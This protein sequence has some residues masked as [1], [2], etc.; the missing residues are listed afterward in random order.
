M[1]TYGKV[2][3]D[4]INTKLSSLNTEQ[5]NVLYE[6]A[7]LIKNGTDVK[8][9]WL[10]HKNQFPELNDA[11]RDELAKQVFENS[12]VIY[13]PP[14]NSAIK[15]WMQTEFLTNWMFYLS[16]FIAICAV[17]A[18]FKNYWKLLI[19]FLI[20]YLAP[21]FR[22]LF[23]PILLTYELWIISV[24]CIFYGCSVEEFVFRTVIIHV[25]LCLLWS[26]STAIFAKEY[27]MKRYV[28]KIENDFWGQ[29]PWTA[30]K[31]IS[32]PAVILTIALS[33]VLYRV[34]DDIFYN[35][36]IVISG[37]TAIYALP[38]WRF[39][40]KYL[41]PVLF[42]FKSD[43]RDRSINSLGGCIVIAILVTSV[44]ILQWNP[45][46]Y[47]VIAALLSLLTISFLIL[48]S[49]LNYRYHFG[50][51]Y[52]LQFVTILFLAAVFMYGLHIQLNEIVWFSLIGA[53]IFII[54][55]YFEIFSFFSDWK[56][57]KAWAWKLLGV[58]VLLWLLAKGILYVSKV[59]F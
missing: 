8:Q 35:Y 23:S 47:N 24:L 40:E 4:S 52:Y 59:I 53:S 25:G 56:R 48:S 3:S 44:L 39:L 19:D 54:I 38:F 16:A 12:H 5:K 41:Y 1:N 32:L 21:I 22:Y 50:N 15:F 45:L 10:Q 28:F 13:T 7:V 9:F 49:K 26:Q 42:P 11:D 55:K 34:P 29:N 2:L 27:L 37:I 18:L 31:T 33:Y 17:I 30:V 14:K 20:Q 36:E 57:G 6:L 58:S 51:Y 43:K 46:F